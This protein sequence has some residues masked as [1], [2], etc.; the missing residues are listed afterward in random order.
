MSKCARL[1]ESI[2][3]NRFCLGAKNAHES[4]LSNFIKCMKLESESWHSKRVVLILRHC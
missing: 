3:Q 4:T 2:L 1:L